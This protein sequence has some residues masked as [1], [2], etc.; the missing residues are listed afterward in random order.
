MPNNH[1]PKPIEITEHNK[2]D[3]EGVVVWVIRR[4]R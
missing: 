4:T 1:H 2:L 3:I